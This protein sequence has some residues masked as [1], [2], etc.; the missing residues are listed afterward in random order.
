MKRFLIFSLLII[1]FA[2]AKAQD[3]TT[4]VNPP[5]IGV[6]LMKGAMADFGDTQIKFI[7]VIS[8]SRCPQ[9]VTCVWAG[10][11]TVEVEI[12]EGG[13]SVG[14]KQITFGALNKSLEILAN[15]V[16]GIKALSLQPYPQSSIP[17]SSDY[18]LVLQAT[19]N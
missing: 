4:S 15:D 9:D 17:K 1:V 5:Q 11:A 3:N 10:E 14:T 18:Y 6:K 7:Q 12:Y 2:F 16:L 19:E 8:D 13:T